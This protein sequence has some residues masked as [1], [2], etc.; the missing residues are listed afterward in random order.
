QSVLGKEAEIVEE[1]KGEKL[2]NME[3]EQLLPFIKTKGSAFHVYGADF[4]STQEGTGIVHIAPAF[5]EDD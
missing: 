2:L 1:F 4:V 3:Y 5:G